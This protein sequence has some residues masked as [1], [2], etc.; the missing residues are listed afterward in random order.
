MNTQAYKRRTA[1]RRG[2]VVAAPTSA[3]W[4]IEDNDIV[5]RHWRYTGWPHFGRIIEKGS[6][7]TIYTFHLLFAFGPDN[8][9]RASRRPS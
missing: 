5:Y 1:R 2:T 9:R 7:I 3:P 8:W 6:V 4:E